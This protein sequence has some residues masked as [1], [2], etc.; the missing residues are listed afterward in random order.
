MG[1]LFLMAVTA[2]QAQVKPAGVFGNHMV[3]QRQKPIPVWGTASPGEKITVSLAGQ[4]VKVKASKTGDWS[5]TLPAMKEG[6]PHL[7]SLTGKDTV[8]FSDVLIGEVWLCS[9]QSNM[10]WPLK[11]ADSAKREIESSANDQI[12]H[13]KIPRMASLQPRKEISQPA[14][15]KVCGPATAADF[16]AVGYFFARELQKRLGVAV[17]LVNSSWGGT[18]VE[19]WTSAEAIFSQPPFAALKEKY[20]TVDT[21]IKAPNAY[22]TLLYNGMIHPLVGFAIR[23]ALWYQGES[24]A[25]RAEQYNMSFPLMIQDWRS[26]WKEDF[27][28]YFVQLTHYQASNGDS[29]NGGSTWAELREAQTNTLKLPHT[30]MAVIIDIGNSKDIHPRN[31]QD[32]GMRLALQAL[33]KTY[34]KEFPHEAP[35]V[36][37]VEF[38]DSRV[39]ISWKHA[40]GGLTVKNRYG[41]VNGFEVAG[42]DRRFYYARAWMEHGKVVVTCDKVAKPVAVRYGWSDDPADLNLFNSAGLPANPFRSDDWPRKTQGAGFG[43]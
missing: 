21:P 26:R 34:G 18:H 23:G 5:V 31:K 13:I 1:F 25:G 14:E 30:G 41:H 20:P 9:G 40:Y 10:E 39:H 24:N 33:A 27:P 29:Q 36:D 22:A 2:P 17:G 4:T 32:V 15:W 11:N 19:T 28:F 12:R 16:T 35:M 7:L 8:T 43:K 6:G 42:D 37:A 38:Q 3:L